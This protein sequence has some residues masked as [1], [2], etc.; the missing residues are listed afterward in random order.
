MRGTERAPAAATATGIA[1]PRGVLGLR[2]DE[3]ERR[4]LLLA[5]L[6]GLSFA[7][8]VSTA[9]AVN[10]STT[11][12]SRLA[13]GLLT[14]PAWV[15]I[16]KAYGLYD[17]DRKRVSHSTV[18]DVPW[19]FHALVVG[20]LGLWTFYRVIPPEPL[21]LRQGIAFFI[22]AFTGIFLA[23]A[24]ARRVVVAVA[25]PERIVFVGGGPMA[26]A[27][28]RKM[29]QHP[30]YA[31]EP[32]G[33]VESAAHARFDGDMSVARLG[34]TADLR[35]VCTALAVDRVMIVSTGSDEHELQE[36]IR[37]LEG[38]DMRVNILPQ[39][40]DVLGSSVEIDDI[41]GITVLGVNP[42]ALTPSSR[43]LKR[44]MDIAVASVTLL[45]ALP[46]LITAAVT[47][48]LTSR[49]PVFFRQD[50]IGRG[51]QK[52][53]IVKLRTMVADAES[54]AEELRA[55]IRHSAWL[56]LDRDPRVTTVGRFLR[57]TSIDELPQLWNVAAAAI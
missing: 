25:S 39:L 15:L 53:R 33:F 19:L 50:R 52:F 9:L 41:E 54:R 26:Q 49:G 57:R 6:V 51:G 48:K 7:L 12:V 3:L 2:R 47:V 29:R 28:V 44:S 35:D 55:Q 31:L 13:W 11:G 17:R 10:P 42:P 5:D 21:I 22:A 45:I 23:R 24:V 56:L 30:E 4:V 40:V 32:V 37:E 16:F 43:F 46:L 8:A 34:T 1:V 36:L 14:M 18:D 27:L 20:S 38:L